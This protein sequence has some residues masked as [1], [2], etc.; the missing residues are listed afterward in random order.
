MRPGHRARLDATHEAVAHHEVVAVAQPFDQRSDRLEVVAVVGVAHDD[1][2]SPRGVDAPDQGAAVALPRYLHDS[3]AQLLGDQ[4]RAVGAAVV[5]D[6]D[7]RRQTELRYRVSCV[8]DA[9]RE[10]LRLIEA[11]HHYRHLDSGRRGR[12][13]SHRGAL[14]DGH[15]ARA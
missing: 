12:L 3:D 5:G 7:L 2:A 13:G 9:L 1:Q 15:C 10:G 14:R 4:L 11:G 8:T 6:D